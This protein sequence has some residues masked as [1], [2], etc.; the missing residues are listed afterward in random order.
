MSNNLTVL[1]N[2]V[3]QIVYDRTK[4]LPAK[5]KSFLD[6]MDND[7]SDSITVNGQTIV[8]PDKMQRALFV[9]NN[10]IEAIKSEEEA[11]A[12]AL[13]AYLSIRLPDLK[14][15]KANDIQGGILIDLIFDEA[16]HNQVAVKFTPP[17]GPNK[18]H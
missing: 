10:L 4:Q 13:C 17:K 11:A 2:G 8:H 18:L 6:K 16:H 12:A 14:Q 5:Q 15:L 1:L 9:A 7:M 3:S